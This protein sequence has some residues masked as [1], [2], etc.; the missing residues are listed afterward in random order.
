MADDSLESTAIELISQPLYVFS[1]CIVPL[2]KPTLSIKTCIGSFY[3]VELFQGSIDSADS[4]LIIQH[5]TLRSDFAKST[6]QMP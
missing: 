2:L 3:S 4:D 5:L 6:R 1:A